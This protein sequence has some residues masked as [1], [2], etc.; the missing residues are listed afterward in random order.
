MNEMN[1]SLEFSLKNKDKKS[2]IPISFN[3]ND[4]I[5]NET[6]LD[7][8]FPNLIRKIC[9]EVRNPLIN[10]LQIIK[11]IKQEYSKEKNNFSKAKNPNENHLNINLN[12][13]INEGKNDV[14]N[15]ILNN[16]NNSYSLN[17]LDKTI[18]KN[19]VTLHLKPPTEICNS[20][21]NF[22]QINNINIDTNSKINSNNN[23]NI[24]IINSHNDSKVIRDPSNNGAY[25]TEMYIN[26]QKIKYLSKL[27]NFSIKECE[28]LREILIS[29]NNH[30]LLLKKIK[31]K[32]ITN[33][34]SLNLK[35]VLYKMKKFINK[36]IE[37]TEKQLTFDILIDEDFPINL[38]IELET[39]EILLFNLLTNAIKFSFRGKIILKVYY[40]NDLNKLSISISDEGIGI[41]EE[42]LELIGNFM[43]KIANENNEYGLGIG[44]YNVKLI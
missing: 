12:N 23:F 33:K 37:I 38:V 44:I 1:N 10:I 22:N 32:I 16:S 24:S 14:Y 21:V 26:L 9:H 34:S 39:I 30:I 20:G 3:N 42:N 31:E 5:K 29:K 19:S 11:D 40:I 27:I 8:M 4:E 28:F 15:I 13:E 17:S 36:L 2:L 6:S 7:L 35:S 18:T 25:N 43:Y 41:K